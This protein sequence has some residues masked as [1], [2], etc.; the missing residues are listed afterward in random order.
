MA[1]ANTQIIVKEISAIYDNA[2][3]IIS[4]IKNNTKL[5]FRKKIDNSKVFNILV[6]L[7]SLK[8]DNNAIGLLVSIPEIVIVKE[9]IKNAVVTS[10]LAII[11]LVVFLVLINI[12]I[13]K[14]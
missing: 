1:A 7:T 5:S 4:S 13:K 14:A 3:D 10:I 2:G 6:P 11:V 9:N 8:D 12:L